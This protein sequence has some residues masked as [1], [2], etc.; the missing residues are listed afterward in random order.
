MELDRAADEAAEADQREYR[1]KM[2]D[3]WRD[4][5]LEA[6]LALLAVVTEAKEILD[7]LFADSR[8]RDSRAIHPPVENPRLFSAEF[9]KNLESAVARIEVIGSQASTGAARR[10][11]GWL[12]EL[13][14]ALFIA[15]AVSVSYA[16][17]RRKERQIEAYRADYL[18][19]IRADL[20]TAD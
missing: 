5:R 4:A 6:H 7:P 2:D 9:T 10:L 12:I 3:R 11:A 19:Q 18:N 15:D 16:E 17:I 1:R 14:Q 13:D 8:T 20:G